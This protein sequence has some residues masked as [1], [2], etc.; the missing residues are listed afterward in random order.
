MNQPL[1]TDKID[2]DEM[3]AII[4]RRIQN[5]GESRKEACV[6]ILNYLQPDS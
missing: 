6:A 1:P 2:L 3:E 5:T 4:L